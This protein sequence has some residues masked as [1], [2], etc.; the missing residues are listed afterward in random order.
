[1]STLSPERWRRLEQ[2]LDGA[3]DLPPEQRT[4]WLTRECD[5]DPAL[6][7]AVHALI[8]AG[9]QPTRLPPSPAR[10]AAPLLSR[11]V[12]DVEQP[13]SAP[14]RIGPWKIVRELGHGG[15]G[16]VYLAERGDEQFEKRVAIKLLRR[17]LGSAELTRRFLHERQILAGLEHQ[18]IARLL[19]GGVADGAPYIV[20]EYVDGQPLDTYCNERRLSV[21]RR[22]A[23]FTDVCSAVQYAHQSLVIHR[24]LKP[25]NVLVTGGAQV[26]LLD[27]GIAKLLDDERA[28]GQAPL[29]RTG[30]HLMTPEYAAPEQVRGG[31]ITTSTD[32]YALGVMLYELLVGE[33]PYEVRGRSPAEIE[34]VV[35]ETEP[36]RPSTAAGRRTPGRDGY[37]R[38]RRLRGDLDTII[39]KALAKDR[40]RRYAS[41]TALVEDLER[42][43]DGLPVHARPDTVLYRARKFVGR[44]RSAVGLSVLALAL[45]S[46]DALRERSLRTRAEGEAAKA[47]AAMNFLVG[48]FDASDP[49]AVS[50]DRDRNL[51]AQ[52][53]LER[54]RVRVDS[55]LSSE[56]A[57]QAEMLDALGRVYANLGVY[58]Q[59]APL[60]ERALQQRRT[61]Q[62]EDHDNV[63]Q[64]M[65]TLGNVYL[66]QGRYGDA[67]PLLREALAVS[68]RV[69]GT[70]SENAANSLDR[71]ATVFEQQSL[72]AEAEQLSREAL[73]IRR[74]LLGD[75]HLAVAE[76]QVNL[77]LLLWWKGDYDASAAL[78]DS[79]IGT[80]RRLLGERHVLVAEA[81]HN[82]AQ[83]QQARGRLAEAES[84]FRVSLEIKRETFQQPHPRVSVHLNNL[85]RLLRDQ[86][87]LGEAEPLFREA[88]AIDRQVFGDDHPYVA[89]TLDNLAGLLLDLGS[90]TEAES[91]Y[92]QALAMNR[93]L[94]GER[95][96]RVALGLSNLATLFHRQGDLAAADEASREA[97][98][99]YAEIFGPDHL[100]VTIVSGNRAGIQRD[101]GALAEAERTY[102]SVLQRYESGGPQTESRIAV[103]L[104]GLGRTLAAAGRCD[105]AKPMLERAVE[106]LR[107]QYG[108]D[109]WRTAEARFGLATC[110]NALGDP[111]AGSTLRSSIS[112]LRKVGSAHPRLLREAEAMLTSAPRAP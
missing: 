69:H 58:D 15:M 97:L 1:M 80:R 89:A 83:V 23:L 64:T 91:L 24:D 95:H 36:P 34:R 73:A 47:H 12:A 62:G 13:E 57:V 9:E 102:R 111:Q 51:S 35:C 84:L 60:L 30:M 28:A 39:L 94:L 33:R 81:M 54:G 55:L 8:E 56:P 17:G 20:M 44:H 18:H 31:R 104:A 85:G 7:A 63:A 45:L 46:T 110:L 53:L 77:A 67:E 49:Y 71:L 5:G 11:L 74:D 72:Y 96:A 103:T 86:G 108:E 88:L 25:S 43:R 79:A 87:R 68:R 3:L 4:A 109:D 16:T 10:D 61:I 29:T 93:R 112:A 42:Y 2:L 6:L 27:F 14:Q 92:R 107:R 50:S 22:L 65:N 78:V 90:L 82:L 37:V 52:A 38:R 99:Q 105:E 21:E 70:S 101:R 106:R 32:V 66:Q 100:F 19:D 41:V 98:D 48:L 26:K 40:T 75:E 76:S 59:A